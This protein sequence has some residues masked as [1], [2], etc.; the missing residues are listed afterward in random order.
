MRN[1]SSPRK[2][3]SINLEYQD[4]SRF[5]RMRAR[6]ICP[7]FFSRNRC[8]CEKCAH[9][10]FDAALQHIFWHPRRVF[11]V[12]VREGEC[13]PLLEQALAYCLLRFNRGFFSALF[14]R[15]VSLTSQREREIH[16]TGISRFSRTSNTA[17]LLSKCSDNRDCKN[18]SSW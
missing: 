7:T 3:G 18:Y 6:A 11:V 2:D 17:I 15:C 9:D 16:D 12:S 8:I 4:F 1:E 14:S 10:R 13:A 5:T